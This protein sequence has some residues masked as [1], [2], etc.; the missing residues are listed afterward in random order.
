MVQLQAPS[1]AVPT[2]PVSATVAGAAGA[3]VETNVEKV[4]TKAVAAA[5]VGKKDTAEKKDDPETE[6][7]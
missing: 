3:N 4:E 6:M 5:G 7:P 1:T 2:V